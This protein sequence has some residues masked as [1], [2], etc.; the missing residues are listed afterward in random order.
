MWRVRSIVGLALLILVYFMSTLRLYL[1]VGDHS[2]GARAS[3]APPPE[4]LLPP[5]SLPPPAPAP[6][7]LQTTE[8]AKLVAAAM[9]AKLAKGWRKES[10][11]LAARLQALNDKAARDSE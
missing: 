9:H 10:E 8:A 7:P 5:P 11:S 4:S 1:S 3:S 6:P 2:S